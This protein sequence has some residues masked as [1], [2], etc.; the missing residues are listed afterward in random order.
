MCL[1]LFCKK[2][3]KKEQAGE[4]ERM[5]NKPTP[6]K[7]TPTSGLNLNNRLLDIGYRLLVIGSFA[8]ARGGVNSR[9]IL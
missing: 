9:H 6:T 4:N 1:Y 5:H 8:T 7:T 3:K 2:N